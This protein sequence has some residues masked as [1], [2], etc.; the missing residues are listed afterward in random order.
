MKKV[1]RI[2]D[3]SND[4]DVTM[5]T[6]EEE[7]KKFARFLEKIFGSAS[8][9][10]YEKTEVNENTLYGAYAHYLA[11]DGFAE[12]CEEEIKMLKA[13]DKFVNI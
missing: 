3:L 2:R 1:Y 13:V 11:T 5:E 12:D 6:T 4:F 9:I 7:I 10:R 8:G